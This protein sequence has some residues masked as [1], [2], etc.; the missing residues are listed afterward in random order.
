M[1][2]FT[3]E[4]AVYVARL[5]APERAV[6]LEVVDDVMELLGHRPSPPPAVGD[7]PLAVLRMTVAPV[8]SPTDPA[9]LRLLPHAS[10]DAEVAQEFRRLTEDDLR[11]GKHGRLL[12]LRACIDA[13]GPDLVVL[14]SEAS[15]V[16]AALTDV[17]LVVSE[18]LGIR[19][20]ADSDAVHRLVLEGVQPQG[21]DR[22][23]AGR[24]LATVH[25]MLSLL[26]E[27]LVELMLARLPDGPA[28]GSPS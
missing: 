8:P 3:A 12:R 2:T 18:R 28:L 25:V 4:G 17:R 10:Q 26:Q 1:H 22:E 21:D 27:S 20:D 19:T 7:D 6:L 13:A 16:A 9:L 5:E 11:A 15:L 14:P 24:L 23:E